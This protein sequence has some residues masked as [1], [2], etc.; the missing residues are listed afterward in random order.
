PRIVPADL[1]R[2][3]RRVLRRG[4]APVANG[5]APAANSAVAHRVRVISPLVVPFHGSRIARAINR[6]F[7]MRRLAR[8]LPMDAVLWAFHPLTYE[9]ES[10]CDAIVYHSID[11][12]HHQD[13]MPAKV[14]LE[15]ERHLAAR[16]DAVIVSSR[17]V[18]D[19]V[20]ALSTQP[21]LLWE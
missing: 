21:P 15:A 11:L 17:G 1:L 16:A 8:Q 3:A 19:H 9:L 20:A 6:I 12:L 10:H 2:M 18:Q 4:S 13:R 14:L 7:V 5:E